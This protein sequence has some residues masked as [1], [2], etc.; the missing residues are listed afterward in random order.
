MDKRDII[1]LLFV[2]VLVAFRLYLKYSKKKQDKSTTVQPSDPISGTSS[3]D[4][5]YEP[6]SD[7]KK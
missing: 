1:I 2:L 6:Y 5:D 7:N 3:E 4:D